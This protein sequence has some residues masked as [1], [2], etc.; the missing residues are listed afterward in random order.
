MYPTPY[1]IRY[2]TSQDTEYN[3]T[4][5][6]RHLFFRSKGRD[7]YLLGGRSTFTDESF[8]ARDGRLK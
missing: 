3:I 7:S 2:T 4:M 8:F 5:N 1:F 6:K